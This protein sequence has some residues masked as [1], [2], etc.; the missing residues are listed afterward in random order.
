MWTACEGAWWTQRPVPLGQTVGLLGGMLSG[1]G[2]SGKTGVW[3]QCELQN[4]N[5]FLAACG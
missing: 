5:S 4:K 1:C 3:A 2:E